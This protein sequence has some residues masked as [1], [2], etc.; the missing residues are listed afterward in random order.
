MKIPRY[1]EP[2]FSMLT[3]NKC[4]KIFTILYI[5]RILLRV[6]FEP[7]YLIFICHLKPTKQR[8]KDQGMASAKQNQT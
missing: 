1:R 5:L 2:Q 4:T 7:Q 8:N 3:L 6:D